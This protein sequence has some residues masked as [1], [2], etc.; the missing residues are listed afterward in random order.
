MTSSDADRLGLSATTFLTLC[1][2]WGP[3]RACFVIMLVA[4][5]AGWF[6]LCRRWPIVG[7]LTCVF[8]NGLFG[9]GGYGYYGRRYRRWR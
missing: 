5:G 2:A 7:W 1:I 8:I 3:S 4:I 6:W 9:Y